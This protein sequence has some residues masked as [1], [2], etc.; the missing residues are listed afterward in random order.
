MSSRR[1]AKPTL[2]KIKKRRSI[3]TIVFIILLVLAVFCFINSNFFNVQAVTVQGNFYLDG[4]TIKDMAE[5][6]DN[7]NIFKLNLHHIE[8]KLGQNHLIKDVSIKREFPSTIVVKLTE[9]IPVGVIVL[10]GHYVEIDNEGMVL[11]LDG[12]HFDLPF[13]TGCKGKTSSTGNKIQINELD[14]ILDMLKQIRKNT[15]LQIA[16]INIT[17]KEDMTFFTNDAIT[18]YIGSNEDMDKKIKLLTSILNDIHSKNKD[19]GMIDIRNGK[20][21]VVK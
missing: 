17:Q 6:P 13:I 7:I 10:N 9:R 3:L 19:V 5:I 14:F 12:T 11:S 15:Q 16:E 8:K 20:Q 1:T 2:A 18:V 4:S 21:A